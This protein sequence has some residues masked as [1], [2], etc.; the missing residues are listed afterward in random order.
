MQRELEETGTMRWDGM[1]DCEGDR[2]ASDLERTLEKVGEV[3]GDMRRKTGKM[4][5]YAGRERPAR[6]ARSER[7]IVGGGRRC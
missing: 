3:G 7:G 1:M 5:R 6:V 2:A 4:R